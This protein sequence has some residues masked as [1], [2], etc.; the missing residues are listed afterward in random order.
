MC[1]VHTPSRE[2]VLA[3]KFHNERV[4][5]HLCANTHTHTHQQTDC[6]SST[7]SPLVHCP[8]SK[9]VFYPLR[10]REGI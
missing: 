10:E 3:I 7:G 8:Y 9:C 4:Y 2:M 6:L 5:S 1:R